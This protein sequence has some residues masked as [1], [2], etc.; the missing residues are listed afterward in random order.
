[1]IQQKR[2]K[3]IDI[4]KGIGMALVVFGHTQ[5]Q[6][7]QIVYQFHLP[8]FFF[9]SG[10]VFNEYKVENFPRFVFSKFK[11][12]WVPFVKYE[13]I[14]LLLHNLFSAIGLYT[15][16]SSYKLYYTLAD[17]VKNAGLILTMGFGEKLAGPLWFLI[18]T[19]EIVLIFGCFVFCLNKVKIQRRTRNVLIVIVALAGFA[20][21]CVTHL[22]RMGSQSLIGLLF[23]AA[24]FLFKNVK[25]SL[26]YKWWIALVCS[27]IVYICYRVNFVDISKLMIT[28]KP[29]LVVSGLSGCYCTL[30]LSKRLPNVMARLFE[31][32]G[33]NTIPVLALHCIS[34]KVVLFLEIV[35]YGLDWTLL[36]AFPTY[37]VSAVWSMLYTIIGV[38]LPLF[39]TYMAQRVKMKFRTLHEKEIN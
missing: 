7:I 17:V 10:V 8:L 21:G 38:L 39:I 11:T 5:S 25:E 4:A 30:Y 18:S 19:L 16:V 2:D 23:F 12:L 1:M 28:Y 26:P 29:L 6:F 20:V 27:G 3:S 31:Y 36:G 37:D 22:P 35:V 33:K 32:C 9:L 24:G 13:I 15:S 34:F 14:F